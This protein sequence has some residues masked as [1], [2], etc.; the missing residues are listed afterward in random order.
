MTAA[1]IITLLLHGELSSVSRRPHKTTR[2]HRISKPAAAPAVAPA[3]ALPTPVAP[4][5]PLPE[6]P[7]K[8]LPG[9][10]PVTLPSASLLNFDLLGA[11]SAPATDPKEVARLESLVARRRVML[12]LHTSVGLALLVATTANVVLGSLNYYD[13][14]GG[15]G[16]SDRFSLAHDIAAFTTLGLFTTNL[17]L[18][19]AAPNPYARPIRADRLLA[20]RLLMFTA[21]AGFIAE[22]ILGFVSVGHYGQNDQA[23]FAVAHL[24]NGSVTSALVYAGA[25][26][27]VF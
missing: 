4:A 22:A 7:T 15:G 12:R 13:R 27:F 26:V 14:F 3:A 17:I 19:L 20:H 8:S 25:L 18:G 10:G 24:V 6:T 2:K 11:T 9:A 21:A 5:T 23:K 1:L 16:Y